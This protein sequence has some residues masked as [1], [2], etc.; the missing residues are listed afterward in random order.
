MV[1][2]KV[3]LPTLRRIP[4]YLR[5][6]EELFEQKVNNISSADLARHLGFTASQVRQDFSAL[7]EIYDITVCGQQGCGYRTEVLRN[8]MAQI[9]RLEEEKSG[10]A[11]GSDYLLRAVIQ[12]MNFSVCGMKLGAIFTDDEDEEETVI[13]T[14]EGDLPVMKL[15]RLADYCQEKHPHIALLA[16][17][18]DAAQVLTDRLGDMGVKGIWNLTGTDI[19]G[20]D[21]MEVED[22][23]LYDSLMTLGARTKGTNN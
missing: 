8:T 19:L 21:D 18:P 22:V 7:R 13:H 12:N 10:I 6:A 14:V 1:K 23:N 16:C 17:T 4:R 2:K 3:P 11:I 20:S 9:L 5:V 15:S